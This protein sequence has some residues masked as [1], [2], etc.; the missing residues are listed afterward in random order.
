MVKAAA[1]N[2]VFPTAFEQLDSRLLGIGVISDE[3]PRSTLKPN[4]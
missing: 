2:A 1:F 4:L 3:E